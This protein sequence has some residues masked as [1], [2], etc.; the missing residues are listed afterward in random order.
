MK[1]YLQTI[2]LPILWMVILTVCV[3][4]AA[5]AHRHF[6]AGNTNGWVVTQ[7]S[8]LSGGQGSFY[9]LTRQNHLIIID[10][11]WEAN[12]PQVRNIIA[13]YNN[14]V[15]AWIITHPHQDHAG[16]F[17]RIF[18]DLGNITV[19]AVYDS[20]IDYGTVAAAGEK[21]DD[22]QVFDTYLAVTKSFANIIP[23][24]RGDTFTLFDLEFTV[25]NAYDSYVTYNSAD[26]TNDSSLMFKVS[27]PHK[28]ILFCGDIK[29]QME[30]T[31]LTLFQNE[32]HCDYMQ[33]AHHGNWSFSEE[34][35]DLTGAKTVL[36]DAPAWIMEDEQYPAVSLQRHLTEQ[37]VTCLDFRTAPNRLFLD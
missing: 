7:Y 26:I 6:A 9:T 36:F 1:K 18:A 11:G 29:Y 15:D 23:L 25:F 33:A 14:H 4:L 35:Y 16:A 5:Y 27:S 30:D 31:I 37:G 3:I 21:W 17:N 13:Q 10:G 12:T 20:P 19:D 32:L 24:H 22:L 34:F 8:D 28:S 2:I